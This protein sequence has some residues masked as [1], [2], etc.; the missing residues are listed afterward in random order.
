MLLE[1]FS[2][3]VELSSMLQAPQVMVSIQLE[4]LK[5]GVLAKEQLC[6]E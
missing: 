3:T 6:M 4:A 5:T 2:T 1:W